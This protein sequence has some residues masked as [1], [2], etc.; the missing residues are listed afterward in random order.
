MRSSFIIY[1]LLFL[2]ISLRG[3]QEHVLADKLDKFIAMTEKKASFSSL[4][5][6][7]CAER[8]LFG[9]EVLTFLGISAVL[10]TRFFKLKTPALIHQ[11]TNVVLDM[12]RKEFESMEKG[13]NDNHNAVNESCNQI[14]EDIGELKRIW[15]SDNNF[16]QEQFNRITNQVNLLEKRYKEETQDIALLSINNSELQKRMEQTNVIH[17]SNS[18]LASHILDQFPPKGSA[19]NELVKRNS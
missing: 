13:V 15:N 2:C 11:E 6:H 5:I 9:V 7:K 18:S 10:I 12:Q 3:Q 19:G 17:R 8:A 1:T 4:L 14:V 16:S